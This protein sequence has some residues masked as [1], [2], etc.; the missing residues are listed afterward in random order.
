MDTGRVSYL[1]HGDDSP[2][3]HGTT[4]NC[5]S[6]AIQRPQHV[7]S[8][9]PA[10]WA[11]VWIMLLIL[12]MSA[13]GLSQQ[14][15]AQGRAAGVPTMLTGELTIVHADDFDNQRGE[16]FYFLTER[17][18]NKTV[19]LRVSGHLPTHVR[20]GAMVTVRG[21]MQG[22]EL[23]LAADAAGSITTV[24]TAAAAVSGEQRTIVMM[25]N[26]L[27]KTLTCSPNIVQDI[28]FTNPHASIDTLY[29]ETSFQQVWL[30]G[31]VVGPF[32]VDYTSTATCS[33]WS[34]AYA[35]DAAA[36]ASGVDLSRYDR[37]VYVMPSNVCGWSGYGTFIGNPSRVWIFRCD[38]AGAYEHELG[39]NFGMHHASTPALSTATTRTSWARRLLDCAR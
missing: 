17:A 32:T 33:Y 8:R 2:Q 26:F 35:A 23:V 27:D 14:T 37:R 28:M 29:Q 30:T 13:H 12:A 7:A 11:R 25:A 20:S 9:P 31:Q 1:L 10:W 36:Q 24:A 3:R 5:R 21:Q 6:A 19:P 39:H 4:G 34:W 22:E 15:F 18:T 16:L 38:R